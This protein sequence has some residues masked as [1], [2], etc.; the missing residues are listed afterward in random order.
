MNDGSAF[1]DHQINQFNGGLFTPDPDLEKLHIP[2]RIF[3]ER[4]Q[5]QNE[6]SLAANRLTLLYLSANY[7]YASN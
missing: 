1:G 3:C 5:G 4:G 6:A 7:N 2:N